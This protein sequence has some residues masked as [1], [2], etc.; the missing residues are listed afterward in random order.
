VG[1]WFLFSNWIN[2]SDH[3]LLDHKLIDFAAV[4]LGPLCYDEKHVAIAR[5]DPSD[6]LGGDLHFLGK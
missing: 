3:E 4:G 1:C 5:G 6:C 2:V